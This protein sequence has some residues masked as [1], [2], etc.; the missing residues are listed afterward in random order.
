MLRL[1][2]LTKKCSRKRTH[3]DT[4]MNATI[5]LSMKYY[6]ITLLFLLEGRH[7]LIHTIILKY[8]IHA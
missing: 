3:I 1:F 7:K 2:S 4:N 8:V 6:T 5:T